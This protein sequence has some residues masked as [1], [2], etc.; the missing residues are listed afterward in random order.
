MANVVFFCLRDVAAAS[1]QADAVTE[2]D[3]INQLETAHK[4]FFGTY[5]ISFIFSRTCYKGIC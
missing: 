2:D 4:D 5:V 3:E 1:T